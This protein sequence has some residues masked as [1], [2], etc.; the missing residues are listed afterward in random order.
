MPIYTYGYYL[1][2]V[3][4]EL[5]KKNKCADFTEAAI[6]TERISDNLLATSIYGEIVRIDP[7]KAEFKIVVPESDYCIV[8]FDYYMTKTLYYKT[9][10]PNGSIVSLSNEYSSIAPNDKESKK[11]ALAVDFVSEKVYLANGES[12]QISVVDLQ[13]EH[14]SIVL[15]D[16]DEPKDI[17][18]DP[19]RR[20][21]FI[22]QTSSVIVLN[23]VA[24]RRILSTPS[25]LFLR[26]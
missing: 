19:P 14:C 3:G 26:F 9:S 12:R 20:L 6:H 5:L 18:L 15:S 11:T 13:S 1:I 16:L 24:T 10:E 7:F 22:L 21:M 23:C 8:G 4:L 2:S 25:L 17:M